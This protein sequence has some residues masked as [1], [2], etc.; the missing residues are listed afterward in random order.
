M[1]KAMWDKRLKTTAWEIYAE[2][3]RRGIVPSRRAAV[4]IAVLMA[5][6]RGWGSLAGGGRQSRVRELTNCLGA[7]VGASCPADGCPGDGVELGAL[8]GARHGVIGPAPSSAAW[9]V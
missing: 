2:E 1:N 8:P 9:S 6:G 7:E 4:L 5:G 3:G